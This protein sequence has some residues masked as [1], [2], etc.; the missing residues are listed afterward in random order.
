MDLSNIPG[1]G[2]GIIHF[3]EELDPQKLGLDIGIMH[4]EAPL[5]VEGDISYSD[6]DLI[7]E[8][9]VEGVK[10]F[11]CSRCLE[12]VTTPFEKDLTLDFETDRKSNI[13]ALP[14]LSEELLVDNPIHVL[15]K[16]DCKGLCVRCGA[17]LNQGACRCPKD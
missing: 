7:L 16:D 13:N 10:V 12:R 3:E 6:E 15:C 14:E 11:A 8:A 17:N 5:F 4:F 2:A 1:T 9:R